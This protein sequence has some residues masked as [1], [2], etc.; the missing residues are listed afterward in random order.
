VT[1]NTHSKMGIIIGIISL[2][3]LAS[4]DRIN[5]FIKQKISRDR[6]IIYDSD[7]KIISQTKDLRIQGT[8]EVPNTARNP[9]K[10]RYKIFYII[11]SNKANKELTSKLKI[12]YL[13]NRG[14]R[15]KS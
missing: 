6:S 9:G 13:R 14:R 5:H 3:R 2:E 12:N 15:G 10:L 4:V 7:T 11:Y 8:P 1:A